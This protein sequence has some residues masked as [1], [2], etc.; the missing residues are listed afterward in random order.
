[1]KSKSNFPQFGGCAKGGQAIKTPSALA[2]LLAEQQSAMLACPNS[3]NGLQ[4]TTLA[5][6]ICRTLR[7]NLSC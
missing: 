6:I 3:E 5:G 1:M 7:G 4:K 2:A